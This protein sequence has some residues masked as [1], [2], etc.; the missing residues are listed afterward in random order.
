[1]NIVIIGAG[2]VGQLLCSDLSK[3][4]N[5]IVLI[6]E[7]SKLIENLTLNN[8]INGLV[9]NGANYDVLKDAEVYNTDIFIAVT[10]KDEINIISAIMAKKIGAKKTIARVRNPEYSKNADFMRESL[11]ID[12]IINPELEAAFEISRSLKFPSA[13]SLETFAN[14]QV[15]MIEL[16]IDSEKHILNNVQ[17]N[18]LKK[19]INKNILITIVERNNEIIIPT[20]DFILKNGD[21]IH[22]TGEKKELFEFYKKCGCCNQTLKSALIIGGGKIA[23]YLI[24]KLLEQKIEVKVIE[25]DEKKAEF[26]SNEFPE[27]TIICGD[28]TMI[29]LLEEENY[30]Y[31]DVC[32]S[33]IGIDEENIIVGLI[34]QKA[35]IKK[36]FAKVNRT[37]LLNVSE[38]IGLKCPITPKKIIADH[39][40]KY[41]RGYENAQYS[42]IETL[43]R[44]LDN[45]VEAIEFNII[46]STKAVGISLA[47]LKTKPNLII[48][49]IIRNNK[50]IFPN[51]DDVLKIGDNVIVVTTQNYLEDIDDIVEK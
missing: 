47:K 18:N 41:V 45:K 13:L 39:I 11:G 3:E 29:D 27:A 44:L 31:Y 1:M 32:V 34:A 35:G 21:K 37:S 14:G 20:G 51:G 33:L 2:K 19:I 12:I 50:L 23:Y 4:G 49:Y 10:S 9:G 40:L 24:K 15:N 43:H 6:E 25:K 5:D 7:N 38:D 26:L 42:N 22:V 36:V 48:A 16:L 17:L 46:N 28:G 8:D 30:S